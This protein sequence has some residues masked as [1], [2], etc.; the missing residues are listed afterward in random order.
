MLW[1]VHL[2]TI[3]SS[4][5]DFAL[6]LLPLLLLVC[7]CF[8]CVTRC[9]LVRVS[10]CQACMHMHGALS[11][12]ALLAGALGALERKAGNYE[13]ALTYLDTALGLTPRHPAACVEKAMIL[14][15][16]GKPNQA[17]KFTEMAYKESTQLSYKRGNME[18]TANQFVR[19]SEQQQVRCSACSCCMTWC[20]PCSHC[21]QNIL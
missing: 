16:Q 11:V 14:R 12:S 13:V 8:W 1:P 19:S 10:R 6:L 18:K 2:L 17:D 21:G 4:A 9:P 5:C 7:V 20:A 15:R 3:G